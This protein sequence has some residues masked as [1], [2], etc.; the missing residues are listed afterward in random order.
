MGKGLEQTFLQ[1]RI[2]EV[3]NISKHQEMKI[4]IIMRYHIC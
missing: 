3:L 1:R 4:K 2:K